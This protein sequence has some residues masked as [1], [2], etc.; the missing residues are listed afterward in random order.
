[1]GR[2]G[3]DDDG[4]L[5]LTVVVVVGGAQTRTLP[6]LSFLNQNLYSCLL[7][8]SFLSPVYLL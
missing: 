6:F 2:R 3:R 7:L 4:D 8:T 1:M 5:D